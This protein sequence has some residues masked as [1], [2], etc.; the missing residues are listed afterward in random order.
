MTEQNNHSRAAAR[1]RPNYVIILV[2]LVV[3]TVIEVAASYLTGGIKLPILIVLAFVKASL[4]VLYF[5]HAKFDSKTFSSWFL[6]G[7]ALIIPLVIVLGLFNP[8]Q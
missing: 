8:G 6:L 1:S 2:L 4:V 5:M 7:L 3:F